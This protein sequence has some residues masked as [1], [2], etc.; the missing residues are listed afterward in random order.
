MCAAMWLVLTLRS[1]NWLN[2]SRLV[3]TIRWLV[4]IRAAMVL[5]FT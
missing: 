2:S 3:L 4:F 5:S 1:P